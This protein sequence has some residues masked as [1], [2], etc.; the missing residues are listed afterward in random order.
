MLVWHNMLS[1]SIMWYQSNLYAILLN[2]KFLLNQVFF[3]VNIIKFIVHILL[4]KHMGISFFFQYVVC[5]I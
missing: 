2:F 1:C 4:K 5:F 3:F